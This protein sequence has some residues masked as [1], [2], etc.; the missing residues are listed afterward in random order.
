MVISPSDLAY[1]IETANTS[2][3]S[4]AAERVGISQP[5]LSLSIKRI[6]LS[7]G[8][9]V[10]IRSKKGVTLTKPGKNLLKHSKILMQYWDQLRS[11]A[12]ASINDISGSL[13][14][15][16]HPS[17]GLYTLD[18]FLPSIFNLFPELEIALKHDL[19][20]KITEQVISL[21]I[22]VGLVINPVRHP[23]LVIHNLCEDVVTLWTNGHKS[24]ILDY[25]SG[26]AILICDPALLQTKDLQDKLKRKGIRFSRIITSN[27]LENI[28]NLVSAGAGIGII[29]SRIVEKLAGKKL[30]MIKG[31]PKF[32]DTLSVIYRVEN[33]KVK[34]LQF[35]VGEISK[36]I[37]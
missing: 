29:P 18:K 13:S 14:L 35:L 16:C 1:F 21:D 3:L 26:D 4:R 20:R 24:K 9:E 34:S 32:K 22:D 37:F 31:A 5:S 27:N 15:G 7:L 33:R 12:L 8:A 6:E 19:S 25:K 30:K 36:T 17:V 28:T 23:D 2:N 11:E 10:F